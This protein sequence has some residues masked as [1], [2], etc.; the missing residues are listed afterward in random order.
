MSIIN[1]SLVHSISVLYLYQRSNLSLLLKD[2]VDAKVG[3]FT[4]TAFINQLVSKKV[5]HDFSLQ[6][7]FLKMLLITI[8]KLTWY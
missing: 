2:P 4:S 5:E 7:H 1:K 6:K 8:V 3:A